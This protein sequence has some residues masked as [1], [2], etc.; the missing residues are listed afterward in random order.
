M[1]TKAK[2]TVG[3]LGAVLGLFLFVGL[4][5][6]SCSGPPMPPMSDAELQSRIAKMKADRT[7]RCI[8]TINKTYQ[9]WPKDAQKYARDAKTHCGDD[10]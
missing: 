4:L 5:A 10:D 1:D 6:E 8:D 9:S 2:E 3:C 7:Q